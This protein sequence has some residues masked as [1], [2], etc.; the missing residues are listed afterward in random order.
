M[1]AIYL[2]AL[3]NTLYSISLVNTKPIPDLP[4]NN[5]PIFIPTGLPEPSPID[6]IDPY[7]KQVFQNFFLP[8]KNYLRTG[9]KKKL[10]YFD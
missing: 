10:D 5:V 1:S 8:V 3:G 4:V 2:S 7:Q 9:G 6:I